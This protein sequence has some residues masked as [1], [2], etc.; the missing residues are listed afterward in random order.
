MGRELGDDEPDPVYLG[1]AEPRVGVGLERP[2]R[3]RRAV[4]MVLEV[5]FDALVVNDPAG[6]RDVA[7][8]HRQHHVVLQ[9]LG[10]SLHQDVV[11]G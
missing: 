9:R 10:R 1:V 6:R 3:G 2:L 4:A 5:A 11:G 8:L 7:L